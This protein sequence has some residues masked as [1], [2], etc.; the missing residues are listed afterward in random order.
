MTSRPRTTARL[1]TCSSAASR[2]ISCPNG[3][4]LLRRRVLRRAANHPLGRV[5][6]Q[7][8]GQAARRQL[9][10]DPAGGRIRAQPHLVG[11][12]QAGCGQLLANDAQAVRY[13]IAHDVRDAQLVDLAFQVVHGHA[14]VSGDPAV[15]ML[16]A[17]EAAHLKGDVAPVGV[18][19]DDPSGSA[20][21]SRKLHLPDHP[22]V[23]VQEPGLV[24]VAELPGDVVPAAVAEASPVLMQPAV[25]GPGPERG[26]H[27][28]VRIPA[29]VRAEEPG[30]GQ[31]PGRTRRVRTRLGRPQVEDP[32]LAVSVRQ[33][34][35]FLVGAADVGEGISLSRRPAPGPVLAAGARV[36]NPG[37]DGPFVRA[38]PQL[39]LVVVRRSD[40]Q[41]GVLPVEARGRAEARPAAPQR[42]LAGAQGQRRIA[43]GVV[44]FVAGAFVEVVERHRVAVR[45]ERLSPVVVHLAS[46]SPYGTARVS[47][48]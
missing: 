32:A 7:S 48:T 17:D 6:A 19:G 14:E 34:A 26:A 18:V 46:L 20:P 4:L 35:S 31:E 33:G 3:D 39:Q 28:V 43:A 5:Q 40:Q 45:L 16:R 23:D 42:L 30:A 44:G 10:R 12:V 2:L 8:R 36:A 22:A 37:F 9:P 47:G 11:Q 24:P 15:P 25:R 29:P 21:G 38:G 41:V 13:R 27:V 1:K